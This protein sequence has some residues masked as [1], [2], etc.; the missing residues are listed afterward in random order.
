M[1]A[2]PYQL[3]GER[4]P[5]GWTVG[6]KL[7]KDEDGTGGNFSA[8]YEC[9]GSDGRHAFLKA[10][11][12]Y[13]PLQQQTGDVIKAL[14]LHIQEV[15]G[16]RELLDECRR[17][18]RVVTAIDHGDIR[19]LK[20]QKL[21][22]PV[23]Y[24]IFERASGNVRSVV[25]ASKRPLHS[26]GLRTLH[27][28]AVGLWQM[29]GSM[30]AHQDIKLSNILMFPDDQGAKVSDLGRA[31]QQGRSV[32]HDQYEWPGDWS[33]APPEFLYGAYPT[34]FNARRFAADL[35]LLGSCACTVFSG[36]H[37]NAHIF[38]DLPVDLRPKIL[39][40]LYSGTYANVLPHIRDI[41]GKS[42]ERIRNTLEKDAPYRDGII[43]MIRQWCEPD[44]YDRGHP[45][46][47]S[48][49]ASAGNVYDLVRYLAEL[50]VLARK[51]TLFEN[52]L[53]KK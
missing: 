19:E 3:E 49:N 47:R 6:K 24:I 13:K 17:M 25:F 16:E 46:T 23:P 43:S 50:D 39:G 34:E 21:A 41:F 52:A 42:L 2:P 29:H 8:G 51:A 28:V 18:D 26:W 5:H 22:I 35:Y 14:Q 38:V 11:D 27:N 48:I 15:Q 10:I 4:L 32:P 37:M 36:A 40:G 31:V 44:P 9:I 33:Y 30:I 12:L 7:V 45:R 20:G 53:R 1:S